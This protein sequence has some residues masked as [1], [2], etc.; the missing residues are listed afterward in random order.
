MTSTIG[1]V[2]EF[3]LGRE[4]WTTY[5]KR[6]EQFFK[7]NSIEG[8]PKKCSVLLSMIGSKA[9]KVSKSLVSPDK[10][11]DREFDEL[12]Q[13]LGKHYNPA[14]SEIVQRHKFH[15]RLSGTSESVSLY[16]SELQSIAEYCN[17]RST[18]NLMPRDK[19][20]CGIQDNA[21]QRCLL[22]EPDLTF[23]KALQIAQ[24]T[25][26]ASKDVK[27]LRLVSRHQPSMD[28]Y[29]VWSDQGETKGK[30]EEQFWKKGMPSTC[31]RCG[32]PGLSPATCRFRCAKCHCCGKTGHLRA[33]C[34]SR[35]Q[36]PRKSSPV[37][38]HLHSKEYPL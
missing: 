23:V 9:Y 2:D 1:K 11:G 31:E 14:T 10:P 27:E 29:Q 24:V 19:L 22:A 38:S 34:R 6:L 18:L 8:K 26:A 5:T 7:A 33:V 36:K 4:D 20:V 37:V 15:M 17:F 21:T 25:E 28:V 12:V 32:K 30:A 13:T 35:P 16:V 3:E